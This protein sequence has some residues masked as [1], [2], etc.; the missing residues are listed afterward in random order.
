MVKIQPV[1]VFLAISSDHPVRACHYPNLVVNSLRGSDFS[2]KA[3]F[4][5]GQ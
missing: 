3:A 1:R 4:K 5:A 2:S